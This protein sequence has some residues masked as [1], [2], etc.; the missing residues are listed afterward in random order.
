MTVLSLTT[1]TGTEW[2]KCQKFGKKI[3]KFGNL[4]ELARCS[5]FAEKAKDR[6]S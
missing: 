4:L 2:Q 1:G 3:R 6:F 5:C